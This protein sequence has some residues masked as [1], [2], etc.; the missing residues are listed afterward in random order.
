M[1]L[2][3]QKN[4]HIMIIR[5]LVYHKLPTNILIFLISIT[6][7]DSKKKNVIKEQFFS[8]KNANCLLKKNNTEVR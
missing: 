6:Y 5:V 8:F 1:F 7:E 3:Q 4:K 2:F